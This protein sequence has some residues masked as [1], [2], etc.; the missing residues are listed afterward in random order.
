[1]ALTQGTAGRGAF[2]MVF[3]CLGLGIPF[4]LVALGFGWVTRVLGFLRRHVRV[5]TV[6]GGTLLIVMGLLLVTGEWTQLMDNLRS[7]VGPASGFDV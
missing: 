5:V 1:M 4:V 7:Q 3:Y 6:V 2:L